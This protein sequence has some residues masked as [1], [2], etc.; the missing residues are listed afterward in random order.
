MATALVTTD[1]DVSLTA[2]AVS[3]PGIRRALTHLHEHYTERTSLGELASIARLSPFYFARLFRAQTGMTPGGYLRHL[4]IERAKMLLKDGMPIS[5][6]AFTTG[7]Y[8]QSHFTRRFKRDVGLPPGRFARV[9]D[10]M[11]DEGES[12]TA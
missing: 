7:F 10:G 5:R 2:P 12:A 8:D 3:H 9:E 1:A 4:R 11:L 6:V